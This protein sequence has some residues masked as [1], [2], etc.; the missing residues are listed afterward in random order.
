MD[1]LSY[2]RLKC[3]KAQF[4]EVLAWEESYW[5]HKSRD[6]WLS[7]GDRNTKLFNSSTKLKR[8]RNRI[9]CIHDSNGNCLSNDGEI[10]SEVVKFFKS[11]LSAEFVSL[12]NNFVN[13]IPSLVN[14]DD[15]RILM[16][17]FT[18]DAVREVVFS[19]H[20]GK[21]SGPDGFTHLF[22]QKCWD[23]VG[24][25]VLLALE[26]SRILSIDQGGFVPGR[27][28]LEGA[29]VSHDI[30]HS[31]SL[32]KTLAMILKLDLLKAY[33]WV[34]WHSLVSVLNH[35]G[36][37]HS[38]VKW[39]FSCIYS[40][41]FSVFLNGS[42][43]GF[44]SSSEGVRKGDPLSPFLFILLAEALSR[45]ISDAR[46]SGLWNGIRIDGYPTSQSDCLF[47]DDTLLFGSSSLEEARVIKKIINDYSFS[48]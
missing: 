20:P 44:F 10:A 2:D 4:E 38:W 42:P 27:E 18:V 37:S 30:L 33:D 3:L 46:S 1:S 21:A 34:D 40:T 26:E 19:M 22:F 41:H 43:T 8:H 23:F 29:I 39:V 31:I 17:P 28:A 11:L 9:S 6:L 5:R 7:E 35:F 24:N 13:S 16:A 25:D 48:G 32:Q 47:A 36:F 12:V 15:S 45:A 14:K